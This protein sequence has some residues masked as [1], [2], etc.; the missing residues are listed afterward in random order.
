MRSRFAVGILLP[1]LLLPASGLGPA[2]AQVDL[3]LA[4]Q[5]APQA[6]P[7][8]APRAPTKGEGL[9]VVRGTTDEAEVASLVAGFREA[10]PGIA[11]SYTKMNSSHLYDGFVEDAAA[12]T[13]TADIVWSSAMDLQIKLVN[14]GYAARHVS[15]ETASLPAWAVWRNEAFGVTAEPI[16]IAYNRT[17]LPPEDVPASRADLIRSLTDHPEAWKGKVAAYDPERSGVGSLILAQ[18]AE[19]T[20]RTWDLVAALGQAGVKLYTRTETMLDRI[21]DGETLLAYGVF[22]AYALERAK[23]DPRIGVVLPSDTTLLVSRIAFIAKDA[24][25]P[26]A[27]RL[28]LDYMLSREGQARLAAQSLTP[29][30]PDARRADDPVAAAPALRPVA[31]GPELLANLDQIRRARMLRRWRR[32]MEGR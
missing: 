18:D 6:A 26:V 8:D 32:A 28:F 9:V 5:D 29:A 17:L 27:A 31:V 22:G 30:R 2:T 10:H 24:R 19:L 1:A 21:A 12:G 4:P 15:A 25:H 14:D 23:H 16:A 7:Q 20:P 13:G 11:V 3:P